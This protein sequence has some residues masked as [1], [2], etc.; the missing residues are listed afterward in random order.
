MVVEVANAVAPPSAAKMIPMVKMR[1][2]VVE[3]N[4]QRR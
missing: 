4:H 3:T 2:G 1:P